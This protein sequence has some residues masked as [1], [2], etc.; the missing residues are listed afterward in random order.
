MKDALIIVDL[1]NDFCPG[2]S[3]AVPDGDAVIPII[4]RWIDRFRREKKEIVAT[5]DAHPP[6]HMSFASRGGPWPPHCVPG[7]W[8]FHIH[9]ELILPPDVPFFHKG[10]DPRQD[11]YSGF[12]GHLARSGQ[13][14]LSLSRYLKRQGVTRVYVAGL[15]TDYCVRATVLDALKEG[16]DT[17][18]IIDGIRG[19]DVQPGDSKRALQEM[20]QNGARLVSTPC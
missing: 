6:D 9:P 3:L 18:V 17:T 15:A 11:A 4:Q 2:G 16:F 5:Q 14:P 12:E 10:T 1:Q 19:V 13:A 7:T 8:G 20:E